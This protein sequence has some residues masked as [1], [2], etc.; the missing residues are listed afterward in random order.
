MLKVLYISAHIFVCVKSKSK[1]VNVSLLI[2][3]TKYIFILVLTSYPILWI[4]FES[5]PSILH[6]NLRHALQ[7]IKRNV[8]T[9]TMHA[10]S[11]V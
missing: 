1:T 10:H 5:R 6:V 9:I 3:R 2:F 7:K 11:D 4:K 8:L